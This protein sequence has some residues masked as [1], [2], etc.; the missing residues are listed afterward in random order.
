MSALGDAAWPEVRPDAVLL[1]PLGSTEQHGP[2]LPLSTDT[3][4]AVGVCAGVARARAGVVVAPAVAIGASGEHQDFPGTLSIGHD[5]LTTVLVEL[6]RSATVTFSRVVLVNAHGG[7]ALALRRAREVLHGEGRD[8]LVWSAAYD[9]PPARS[10]G[11]GAGAG[12]DAHAG[13][14]ET[15][16]MLA[17]RPDLVRAGR[18]AGD[19]RPLA[20]LLPALQ[21]SGVRAVSPSGVLGDPHDASPEEGQ[22][23]L[24]GLVRA[25]ADA[26][27]ARWPT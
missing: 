19:T 9:A 6:V 10:P 5:A 24:D 4:I 26:I 15:S 14:A 21:R 22:R 3:D 18:D 13:R 25:L 23:L 8:V 12:G 16:L 20:D 27:T 17:L 1:V 2:H 7:N 11:P